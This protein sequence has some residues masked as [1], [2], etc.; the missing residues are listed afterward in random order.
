ML[1]SSA[2]RIV[3]TERAAPAAGG[4]GHSTTTIAPVRLRILLLDEDPPDARVT[5]E[6]LRDAGQS[7]D[8][9]I[10][11]TLREVSADRLARTHCVLIEPAS[12]ANGLQALETLRERAPDMP[13]VVLTR[14][15]DPASAMES[16]RRGAQDHLVKAHADGHAI[17]RAIRFAVVRQRLQSAQRRQ[18]AHDL[19][20]HDDVIR[21]LFA[22]G[23]AM[24][25]TQQRSAG[26]PDIAGRITD[27]LNGLHQV[28]QQVRSTLI[29]TKPES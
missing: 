27:H 4:I 13:V 5:L 17:T 24:Q 20:L 12:D 14:I 18:A 16:L 8:C 10:G 3:V 23:M 15:E 29:Q 25:T 28:L 6:R 11:P 7:I 26:E 9:D 19:E 21:R 2:S 22:I 1:I